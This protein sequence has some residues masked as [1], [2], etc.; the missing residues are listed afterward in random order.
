M[1]FA[2]TNQRNYSRRLVNIEVVVCPR[3]VVG[4]QCL[5][6]DIGHSRDEGDAQAGENKTTESHRSLRRDGL[7][8]EITAARGEATRNERHKVFRI[9][10]PCA[11]RNLVSRI[12]SGEPCRIRKNFSSIRRDGTARAAEVGQF[13]FI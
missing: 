2:L 8:S 3:A 10:I 4:A 1:R 5:P 12:S 9:L 6:C 11:G 7:T 13:S